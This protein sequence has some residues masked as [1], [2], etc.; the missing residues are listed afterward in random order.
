MPH[1]KITRRTAEIC[2]VKPDMA[3][4]AVDSGT[5]GMKSDGRTAVTPSGLRDSAE[6]PFIWASGRSASGFKG[7]V[8]PSA[9]MHVVRRRPQRARIWASRGLR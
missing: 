4:S 5:Q 9:G 2:E 1:A 7:S 8:G 6:A 3:L